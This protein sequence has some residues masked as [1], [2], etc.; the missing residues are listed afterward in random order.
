MTNCKLFFINIRYNVSPGKVEM[1]KATLIYNPTA[2]R[3]PAGPFIARVKHVLAE[4]GWSLQVLESTSREYLLEQSQRAVDEG[5]DAVFVAG[6]DGSVGAVASVLASTS[7]AL[8]VLPAGTANVWARELGL[9]HLDWIHWFALE[10]A[11]YRLSQGSYRLTD[12]GVCN[13][14]EFLLWAGIGLDAEIVNNIEPRGRLEKTLGTAQ[15][16]TLALWETLGWEGIHLHVSAPC[17]EVEGKFLVAI[18][19]NIRAYAGGLV[20]LAS[21]AKIDDGLLDFWLFKGESLK[22]VVYHALQ[23]IMGTHV[24]SSNVLHFQTEEATFLAKD[25]IKMQ[26][27]GEPKLMNSPIRFQIREKVLRVLV[28]LGVKPDLFSKDPSIVR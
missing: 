2:G 9:Q 6:G 11:A 10:D 23:V 14:E 27:D 28:P 8:A 20:E 5:Q 3:F 24:R 17:V 7:T 12:I 25:E 13:D 16:A 15:Y 21:D 18:A 1:P 19:S 26:C 4:G 22:D